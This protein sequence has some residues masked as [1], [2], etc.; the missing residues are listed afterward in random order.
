MDFSFSKKADGVLRKEQAGLVP[1][2]NYLLVPDPILL[3]SSLESNTDNDSEE[4]IIKESLLDNNKN[5]KLFE[6][7]KM[8]DKTIPPPTITSAEE[9]KKRK[10]TEYCYF[11]NQQIILDIIDSVARQTPQNYM[12]FSDIVLIRITCSYPV[13]S[14]EQYLEILPRR[15][16]YDFDV[17]IR[18]IF[19]Q[20][21][22]LVGFMHILANSKNFYIFYLFI[23]IL[24][25]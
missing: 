1:P 17:F 8:Q 15:S 9:I 2:A 7:E 24:I 25:Y 19:I 11:E 4:G 3:I 20:N 12:K 13:P 16:N 22:I 14:D 18:K 23:I 6:K 10:L 21:P 5:R